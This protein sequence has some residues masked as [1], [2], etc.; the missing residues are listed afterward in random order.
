MDAQR[1]EVLHVTNGDTVVETVAHHLILYLFPSLQRL[2]Y[3]Y[4]WR[5]R[6]SL[7]SLCQQLFLI[8]AEARTQTT[9]GIG[10]TQNDREAQRGSSLLYLLDSRTSL[11]LDGL[12]TYLVELLHKEVTVFR[13][14]NGLNRGTQHL[15]TVFL[16]DTTLIQFYTTVEGCLATK[17]EQDAVGTFFLDDTFHKLCSDRLE[18]DLVCDTFTG[19]YGG[20]IGVDE[21][22]LHPFFFQGFQCLCTAV[23][24]LTSLTNLQCS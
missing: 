6:E 12:N 8:I 21:H 13:I 23:V 11:A 10:S 19:L 4:L 9:Q 14:D 2:L 24:K 7:L 18:I 22:A 15:H 1:V 17:A 16:E 3:Q 20:N 5:E